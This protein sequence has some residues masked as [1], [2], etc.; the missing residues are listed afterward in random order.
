MSNDAKDDA[1][2][3]LPPED[4]AASDPEASGPT[5]APSQ[6]LEE[7]LREASDAVEAAASARAGDAG[8]EAQTA[9]KVTIEMLASELQSLKGEYE[10]QATELEKA[11][12]SQLRLQAEFENFRRR[13]L[14]ERQEAYNYGHQ[15]I[16]KDLL[17]TVDNLDRAIEHAEQSD[18]EDLAGLLQGVELVRR[19]LL[20]VLAKHGVSEIEAD[21]VSF[22]P[23]VHEAMAQQPSAEVP[24]NTVVQVLQKG[25]VLR[26]RMLRPARVI[27]A[28]AAEPASETEESPESGDGE[29]S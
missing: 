8:P 14:K 27:I 9:D 15:N 4:L 13:G 29:T 26:D 20:S 7:A 12:E 10:G 11:R 23:A 25:Y 28:R 1:A 6:E 21:G 3:D 17:A 18:G 5:L 16:V 19:E 24:A 2:P 22:D